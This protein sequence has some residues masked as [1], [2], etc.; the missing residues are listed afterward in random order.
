MQEPM[1]RLNGLDDPENL[2]QRKTNNDEIQGSLR[3]G[4]KS[5]VFG[6]DDVNFAFDS[7]NWSKTY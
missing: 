2:H 4:G 5:A 1:E 6:R 3:C 7:G